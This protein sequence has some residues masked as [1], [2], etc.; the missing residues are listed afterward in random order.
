LKGCGEGGRPPPRGRMAE[1]GVG[2][3]ANGTVWRSGQGDQR[4][5]ITGQYGNDTACTQKP[6][7]THSFSPCND[8]GS[9]TVPLYM[10]RCDIPF[11]FIR[12]GFSIVT[13]YGSLVACQGCVIPAQAPCP[14]SCEGICI[15]S[16]YQNCLEPVLETKG[17]RPDLVSDNKDRDRHAANSERQAH[18]HAVAS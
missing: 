10:L 17:G 9:S 1:A 11:Q 7:D 12:R 4:R 2:T 13:S 15:G 5:A 14:E 16:S 6:Q 18:R 3:S 8:S